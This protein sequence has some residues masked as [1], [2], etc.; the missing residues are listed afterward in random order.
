MLTLLEREGL[1]QRDVA[2]RT[3]GLMRRVGRQIAKETADIQFW[4][5]EEAAKIIWL[6][7]KHEPRIAPMLVFLF[8]TGARRGEA[9]G[10]KW[11]DVDFEGAKMQI[12]RSITH[13]E[14][15]TPKSG[16]SRTV[17]MSPGLAMEL[18]ALQ[19]VRRREALEKGWPEIPEWVFCSGTGT[20][21]NGSNLSYIWRR[22]QLRAQ[23]QGIR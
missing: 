11:Q 2:S 21:S 17:S 16:K 3:G 10:L 15:T 7:R 20:A 5:R 22:L 12:R 8:A 1:V 6:A 4:S 19:K 14:V 13:G 9:L 23:A 18:R